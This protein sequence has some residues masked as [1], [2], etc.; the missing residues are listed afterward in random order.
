MREADILA[1]TYE[2]V[3][4]ISR[5]SDVEN[6]ETGITGQEYVSI[7]EDVPCALSQNRQD[8]LTVIEGDMINV[9]TDEYNLF[10]RPEIT[11]ERGDRVIIIQKASGIVFELY[12]TKPF[13]YSSHCEVGLTG[14]DPIG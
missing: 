12:A 4:T 5:L 9:A 10:V 7:H 2:D 14:R 8:G 13:Y 3:C 6:P 11:I 1:M